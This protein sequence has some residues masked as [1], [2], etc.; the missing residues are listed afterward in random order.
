LRAEALK[1]AVEET[2]ASILPPAPA[3]PDENGPRSR[4][5]GPADFKEDPPQ[6][7][8][9]LSDAEMEA[10]EALVLQ[11]AS[12]RARAEAGARADDLAPVGEDAEALMSLAVEEMRQKVRKLRVANDCEETLLI[13]GDPM[14]PHLFAAFWSLTKR[15]AELAGRVRARP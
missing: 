10:T 6:L 2:A 9:S 15:L 14:R 13:P 1:R 11:V 7:R 12:N 4:P 5:L 3:D 8:T